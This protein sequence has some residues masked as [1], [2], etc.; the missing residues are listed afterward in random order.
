MKIYACQNFNGIIIII[1]YVLVHLSFPILIIL[2]SNKKL[3]ET[4]AQL[5]YIQ[6]QHVC[7]RVSSDAL[8]VEDKK[9]KKCM[10]LS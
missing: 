3:E 10:I 5:G 9:K 4:K 6:K 8:L 2:T 7:F 1:H